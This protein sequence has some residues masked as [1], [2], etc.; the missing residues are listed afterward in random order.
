VISLGRL[1]P[2]L[3]TLSLTPTAT[4]QTPDPADPNPNSPDATY[5]YQRISTAGL[6]STPANNAARS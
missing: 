4:G 5:A 2:S 1:P 6:G 3:E